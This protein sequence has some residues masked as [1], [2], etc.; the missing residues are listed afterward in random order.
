MWWPVWSAHC[1]NDALTSHHFFALRGERNALWTSILRHGHKVSL[2]K[3]LFF[4]TVN[5]FIVSIF[6]HKDCSMHPSITAVVL[7]AGKGTRMKSARAKVL[8]EVFGR[9]SIMF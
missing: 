7:A 1:K 9:C 4:S 3:R 5:F 2:V 8:H 6:P